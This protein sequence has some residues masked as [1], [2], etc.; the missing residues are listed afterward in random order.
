MRPPVSAPP[1]TAVGPLPSLPSQEEVD[2]HEFAG[3]IAGE[4]PL[5][6]AA[7]QWLVRRLDG[8][9][10]EEE[11]ELQEWLAADPAHGRAL[12]ALEGVWGRMDELPDEGV[13]ALK[14][15][16]PA[17]AG[18]AWSPPVAVPEPE[19]RPAGPS[20]PRAPRPAAPA[21]PRRRA[22][23]LDLGR[24]VPQAA[25]AALAFGLVGG[26]WYGWNAWQQQPTFTQTLATARGQSKEVRL[27]DGS[28]LWLDT[29]TRAEVALYRQRR[30]VRLQDGQVLF[31][32][33]SNAEQPFDVL[34]G[35]TRVTVVGTRFSV[36]RT[37]SGLGEEGE[38]SV[39]VEEGRVRVARASAGAASDAS[40]P[41]AGVEL[42]AGQSVTADAAGAL[43]AV[44][45]EAATPA[46]WREGRISF[47][48]TPLAQA[49][50][51][52]ERYGDTGLVIRDPAVA[53]LK[54]HGSF[55]L[56][57]VAA[58]ARALPRVLPVQLRPQG[59]QT[60]IVAAR[61]GG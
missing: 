3:F 15:G 42:G 34:A 12:G 19:P 22:W 8:L 54:V 17:K 59:G 13:D 48:A 23:F 5:D 38:V 45:S 39:V 33:Q 11:A 32:V 7:A 4:D 36:R 49:L 30:E 28:T 16:L 44:R 41:V 40:V 29:A 18:A 6:A 27:P 58:F 43:G 55:D 35:G 46:A 25:A 20:A 52:F 26:G 10:P 60:E 21:S 53:A 56:R 14:A 2:A 24:L 61:Q 37:R 51:E 50:A 31:A 9:T 1:A 57:E 47:N